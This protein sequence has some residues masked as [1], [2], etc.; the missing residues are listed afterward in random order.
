MFEKGAEIH[1]RRRRRSAQEHS[2]HQRSAPGHQCRPGFG[3]DRGDP[4]RLQA[5]DRVGQAVAAAT[6]GRGKCRWPEPAPVAVADRPRRHG[7]GRADHRNRTSAEV[8]RG[9]RRKNDKIDAAGAACVAALQGDCKPVVADEHA[10]ALRMLD[11]RRNN[12]STNRTRTVN[13]LHALLRELLAD[14]AP[15]SLTAPRRSRSPAPITKCVGSAATVT[16]SSTPR[17][18][19]SPWCRSGCPAVPAAPTT[20]GAS[21]PE[22]P[23]ERPCAA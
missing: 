12:L 8:S 9:G 6:M 17:S 5:F 22:H 18:T 14:G 10:D 20:I 13:Q 1:S 15:T 3:P 23:H 11:E 4:G 2:H 21:R 16:G 19:R 7:G